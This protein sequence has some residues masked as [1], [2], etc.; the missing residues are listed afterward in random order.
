MTSY[1]FL[2][3]KL[4]NAFFTKIKLTVVYIW[5]NNQQDGGNDDDDDDD[6]SNKIETLITTRD[7]SSPTICILYIHIS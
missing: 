6:E 3:L 5:Y 2:I 1:F 7:V 4:Y